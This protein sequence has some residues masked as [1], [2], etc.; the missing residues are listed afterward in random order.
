MSWK[1]EKSNLKLAFKEKSTIITFLIGFLVLLI[2]QFLFT[3][4]PLLFGNLG[5]WRATAHILSDVLLAA[6]FGLNLSLL[7]YKAKL[8]SLSKKI[9]ATTTLGGILSVLITGCPACSL[10]LASYLGLASILSAL[11]FGGLEVK[12]IGLLLL[13]YSTNYL[14]KTL[15]T[16]KKK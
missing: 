3:D 11:P 12:I 7:I 16:C 13:V 6:L 15:T 8:A 2:I 14:L 9:T 4:I 1:E 10:T 5:P